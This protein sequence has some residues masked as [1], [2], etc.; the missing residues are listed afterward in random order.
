MHSKFSSLHPSNQGGLILTE[1]NNLDITN[2]IEK[3]KHNKMQVEVGLIKRKGEETARFVNKHAHYFDEKMKE[4][5]EKV[6]HLEKLEKKYS[7]S[8]TAID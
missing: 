2:L 4:M 6:Q 1:A 3:D 8:L 5:D 7:S